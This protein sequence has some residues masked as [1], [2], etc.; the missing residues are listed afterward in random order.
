MRRFLSNLVLPLMGIDPDKDQTDA[1]LV[2][3]AL[4]T[5]VG[6]ACITVGLITVAFHITPNIRERTPRT[7]FYKDNCSAYRPLYV[8][9]TDICTKTQ[10]TACGSDYTDLTEIKDK[11]YVN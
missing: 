8:T 2:Q 10:A 11:L 6:S 5:M 3:R 7:I 1:V 4:Y 9:K